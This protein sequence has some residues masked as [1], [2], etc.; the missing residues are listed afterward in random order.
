[1]IQNA[2]CEYVIEIV[3]KENEKEKEKKWSGRYG[4]W[5]VDERWKEADRHDGERPGT[6]ALPH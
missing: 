6:N 1:M 3:G 4:R 5:Q 2:W